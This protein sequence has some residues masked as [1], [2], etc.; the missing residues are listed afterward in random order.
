MGLFN[1]DVRLFDCAFTRLNIAFDIVSKPR[2]HNTRIKVSHGHL[3]EMNGCY[4]HFYIGPARG[5][6]NSIHMHE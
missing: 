2:V 3:K 4:N 5:W 6:F 1:R